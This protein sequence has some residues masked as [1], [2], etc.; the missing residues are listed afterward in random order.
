MLF[1]FAHVFP[2][3]ICCINMYVPYWNVNAYFVIIHYHFSNIIPILQIYI[4]MVFKF[5][6][7]YMYII[8]KLC[9][10]ITLIK[11]PPPFSG[12][13]EIDNHV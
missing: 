1:A 13:N 3:H 2:Y 8:R 6:D 10:E 5:S 4:M 7:I 9:S 12:G 11:L